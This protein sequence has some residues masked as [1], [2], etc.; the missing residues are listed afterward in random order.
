LKTIALVDT[1]W[2]GHHSTYLKFFAK[3]LLDLGNEVISLCPEPEEMN[4]WIASHCPELASNFH[5]FEL[6]EPS[7]SQ[8]SG[9][10]LQARAMAVARWQRVAQSIQDISSKLG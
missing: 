2:G 5:S 7:P 9:R 4:L 3:T 8:F 10:Q 1:L 6:H